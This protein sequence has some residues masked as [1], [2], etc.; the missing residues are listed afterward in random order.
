MGVVEAVQQMTVKVGVEELD[1]AVVA[2]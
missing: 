1:T 2:D